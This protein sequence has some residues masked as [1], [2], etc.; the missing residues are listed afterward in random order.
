MKDDANQN[1]L[2]DGTGLQK[3][4]LKIC[5]IDGIF[6]RIGNGGLFSP[7]NAAYEIGLEDPDGANDSRL[8]D[9]FWS[10]RLW[11]TEFRP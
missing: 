6:L 11:F 7:S 2:Q 10:D 9:I 4:P 5:C 8:S 1:L 3:E